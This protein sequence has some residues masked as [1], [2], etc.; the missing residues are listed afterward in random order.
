MRKDRAG[1]EGTR[2][3]GIEIAIYGLHIHPLYLASTLT[4]AH[5]PSS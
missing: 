5:L 2:L 1:W 4:H 3:N